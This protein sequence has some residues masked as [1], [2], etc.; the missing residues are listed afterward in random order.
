M[1]INTGVAEGCPLLCAMMC[2]TNECLARC[3]VSKVPR[4]VKEKMELY[5]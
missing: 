5:L 4:Q 2:L 1:E 3:I